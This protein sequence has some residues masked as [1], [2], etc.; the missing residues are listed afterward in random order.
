M[1]SSDDLVGFNAGDVVAGERT[2]ACEVAASIDNNLGVFTWGGVGGVGE[3]A[4]GVDLTGSRF[5]AW[6]VND[7]QTVLCRSSNGDGGGADF[8]RRH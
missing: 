3:F 1:I 8:C 2:T 5:L 4:V 7:L 6:N